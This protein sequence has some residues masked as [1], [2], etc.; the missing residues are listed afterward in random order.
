MVSN[1]DMRGG[2]VPIQSGNL[3]GN[4][5]DINLIARL[6]LNSKMTLPSP[7]N[8]KVKL[9][10]HNHKKTQLKAAFFSKVAIKQEQQQLLHPS[11]LYQ[12]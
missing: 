9:A 2:S 5:Y 3:S 4:S 10:K 8:T 11:R 1:V 7:F 12:L 6:F